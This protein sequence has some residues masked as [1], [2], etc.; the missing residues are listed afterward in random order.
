MA[1]CDYF[2][3]Q[4]ELVTR[5]SPQLP[6]TKRTGRTGGEPPYHVVPF[7][8]DVPARDE[9]E[10]HS[11]P[12][13][14]QPPPRLAAARFLHRGVRPVRSAGRSSWPAARW[15]GWG[16]RLLAG[17]AAAAWV[18]AS[19]DGLALGRSGAVPASPDDYSRYHNITEGL[20]VAAGIPK[21]ALY[22]VDDDEINA[23]AIGR[24][25]AHAALVV[26]TGLLDRLDRI[27]LEGVLAQQLSHIRSHDIFP[28]T[29]AVP[30]VGM[31][32]PPLL[33]LAVGT[34]PG[35]AGRPD[36]GA[37]DPLP[38]RAHRRPGEDAHRY[39]RGRRRL[40]GHRPPLAR[41]VTGRARHTAGQ[42]DRRPQ[43]TVKPGFSGQAPHGGAEE[44]GAGST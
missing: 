19:A 8:Q 31:L 7:R 23:C 27:E 16:S 44:P 34:R 33:P 17:L 1:R 29:V 42:A 20:C 28:A 22:V 6:G 21:P 4:K 15:S 25:P 11:G 38:A 36:R 10:P 26:T 3:S 24:D 39:G 35:G 13:R 37:P 9:Q 30:L 5:R 2:G 43:G 40:P 32:A 12:D 14:H 41:L 18:Y